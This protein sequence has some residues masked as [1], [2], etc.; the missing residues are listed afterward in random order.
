MPRK[1]KQTQKQKQKQKQT[2]IV[3]I[4]QPKAK[5]RKKRAPRRKPQE[6]EMY[7]EFPRTV[8]PTPQLTIYGDMMPP[9]QPSTQPST[10]SIIEPTQPTNRM[11]ILEDI[12][13]VGTEG[14]V[15][16][17][18]VPTKKEQLAELMTPVSL[19]EDSG[20][21]IARSSIVPEKERIQIPENKVSPLSRTPTIQSDSEVSF[22]LPPFRTSD[23]SSV[24]SSTG[25]GLR[26]TSSSDKSIRFPEPT[27]LRFSDLENI[28]PSPYV[29]ELS[30]GSGGFSGSE[31]EAPSRLSRNV[32]MEQQADF[33]KKS[34]ES[35][36]LKQNEGLKKIREAYILKPKTPKPPKSIAPTES[37]TLTIT[38]Y[39]PNK[40]ISKMNKNELVAV[41]KRFQGDAPPPKMNKRDLYRE[42]M[43]LVSR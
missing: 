36:A 43:G 38:P 42:V 39:V 41:Y 20:R 35:Y 24:S 1:V 12:G 34:K 30:M 13:N 18:D 4:E 29:S 15:Q 31:S 14:P 37:D 40:P 3:N 8:Y 2:V 16:I 26:Y 5:P 6:V 7:R 25:P 23:I 11:P 33:M 27:T 10:R 21:A 9:T 32:F 17:I 28:G 19:S 22:G